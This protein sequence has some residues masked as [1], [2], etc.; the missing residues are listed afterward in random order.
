MKDFSERNEAIFQD[1]VIHEMTYP[2]IAKKY[3][4]T[5]NRCRQIVQKEIRRVR[6]ARMVNRHNEKKLS[7]FR[8]QF[9]ELMEAIENVKNTWLTLCDDPAVDPIP[10]SGLGL[11]VRTMN[12]LKYEEITDLRQ[13]RKLRIYDLIRLPNFGR[14]SLRELQ[15]ACAEHGITIGEYVL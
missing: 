10:I 11:S 3:D 4:M 1:R 14:K 9:A 7:E 6:G 5:P 8:V 12:V 13:L 15:T 2:A